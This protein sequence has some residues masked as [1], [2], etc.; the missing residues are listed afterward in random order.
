ML[1]L[2]ALASACISFAQATPD[3]ICTLNCAHPGYR[4]LTQEVGGETLMREYILHVPSGY[5]AA[6]AHPLVIVYHG[7]G[8]CASYWE[9]GLGQELGFNALADEQGF[10]VAYPQGPTVR[11]RRRRI[12]SPETER[13]STSMT[14]MCTSLNS[15]SRMSLL[16]TT[17]PRT[18]CMWLGT[19]T[20]A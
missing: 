15:S 6:T 17:W 10:L 4:S 5:D 7:F 13:A 12:G 16:T 2:V 9:E 1:T 20:A 18:R 11:P 3:T 8:D 19:A 14:T